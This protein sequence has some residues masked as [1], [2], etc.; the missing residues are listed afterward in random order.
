MSSTKRHGALGS[1]GEHEASTGRVGDEGAERDRADRRRG[2]D[3][4][5]TFGESGHDL[6]GEMHRETRVFEDALLL[7]VDVAVTPARELEMPTLHD[8]VRLEH[9]EHL[10]GRHAISSRIRLAAARG[11]GAVVI[12]RPTTRK[13]A[14]ASI[15]CFALSVR[16]WSPASS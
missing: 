7:Q 14:P 13:S 8:V 16:A 15:A 9:L 1:L 4:E 6:L 3:V 12:G 2:D 10:V 11:S 5:R